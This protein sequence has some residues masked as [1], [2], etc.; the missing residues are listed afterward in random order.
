[1][2]RASLACIT[3]GLLFA[4]EVAAQTPDAKA[5]AEI[6]FDEGK[7]LLVEGKYA[8]ACSKLAESVKL[9]PGIGAMLYLADCYEKDGRTAS[10]WAEFLEAE[11]VA[12]TRGDRRSEVARER[13]DAL[14]PKLSKIVVMVDPQAAG[15]DVRRDGI[16][17]GAAQWGTELPID[18][19]D[20]VLEASAAGKLP[21]RASVTIS[22]GPS[23]QVVSVPAL[24]D[25]PRDEPQTAPPQRSGNSQRV[26]GA[27][28]AGVGLLGVGLGAYF[29]LHA[30]ARLSDSNADGHCNAANQCDDLGTEARHDASSSALASTVFFI[31]GGALLAGGVVLYFTAPRAPAAV[32]LGART[33]A[34]S[35]GLLTLSGAF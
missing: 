26:V 1:L 5:S 12:A 16:A 19:G 3:A 32:A 27:S 4:G 31:A 34:R 18:P 20:H 11:S 21:W 23:R 17:I 33:T 35:G 30:S 2:K 25:A 7:A 22:A 8:S 28:L 10:A 15:V 13:A 24:A 14:A 9:D 29:G 6:L